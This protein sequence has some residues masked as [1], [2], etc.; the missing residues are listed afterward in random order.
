MSLTCMNKTD[1]V[2]ISKFL[3]LVLRHKPEEI[4]LALD[5]NG[6]AN[7][8][9]IIDKS[10]Q[11]NIDFNTIKKIVDTSEK[12]RF[13]LSEDQSKIRANQGHS[14][15]VDLD[16]QEVDPPEILYHGTA[17]RSIE[18]IKKHGLCSQERNHVH[19]SDDIKTAMEVGKR[20]GKPIILKINAIEMY[21]QG[22]QFYLSENGVWLTNN[23][24]VKFIIF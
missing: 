6:W 15:P 5:K 16:L 12:K 21:K 19:L 11:L 3:S 10:K 22:M 23:V 2:K 9:D 24:P 14:V 8:S 4:D 13:Q 20:Y 18:S 17:T 7:V 1:R